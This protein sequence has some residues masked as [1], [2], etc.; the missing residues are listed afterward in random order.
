MHRIFDDERLEEL[1]E[2]YQTGLFTKTQLAVK[3]GCSVT[4]I[5]LWLSPDEAVREAKFKS[6]ITKTV[7]DCGKHLDT[8][9]KCAICKVNM[10][11]LPEL[12]MLPSYYKFGAQ[13]KSP[14]L[15]DGCYEE[16]SLKAVKLTGFYK[17]GD[18]YSEYEVVINPYTKEIAWQ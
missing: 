16:Y 9:K 18:D 4:T 17:L 5:C 10:H 13:T 15:C 8:H 1:K 7:C 11:T 6:R 12:V 3:Y 14:I 2:L